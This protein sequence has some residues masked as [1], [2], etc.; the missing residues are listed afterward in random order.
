MVPLYEGAVL[1]SLF[2]AASVQLGRSQERINRINTFPIPDGDSGTNM[3][4][5]WQAAAQAAQGSAQSVGQLIKKASR[6][7]LL[8]ARGNS[9][10]ILSQ[11]VAGLARRMGDLETFTVRDFAEALE[12]A[13]EQAY[14]SVAEPVEGTI[15]TVMRAAAEAGR[16]ASEQTADLYRFLDHVVEAA[17]DALARTPD[18]LPRLR[19]SGVVDAGGL[20]LLTILEAMRDD[21]DHGHEAAGEVRAAARGQTVA[22]GAYVQAPPVQAGAR[23]GLEVQ[24]LV[25]G[26]ELDL[27]AMQS[28]LLE[29]GES[30]LVVG[31]E[32]EAKVHVHT[33]Q[34]QAVVDYLASLGDLTQLTFE[35]LDEQAKDFGKRS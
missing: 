20:G 21:V 34:P 18:L 6:A 29:M 27:K 9:G 13:A 15:L 8:A 5:T 32:Q 10:I 35:N 28:R 30:L 31:D 2:D 3:W 23:Y 25:Q 24:C 33:L 19:E 11:I 22:R 1:A 7:A 4:F 16:R 17:R 14:R 26:G 12:S